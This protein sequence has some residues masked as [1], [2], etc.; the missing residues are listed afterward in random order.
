MATVRQR[1]LGRD[2]ARLRE[3][4]GLSQEQVAEQ[5]GW[6]R[7]KVGRIEAAST[8]PKI[9]DVEALLGLYGADSAEAAMLAK[10]AKDAQ[11]RGW[12]TAFN[13]VFTGSFVGLEDEACEIRT[14]ETQFVPGLLQ[15]EAYAR[16]V[17][18][19]VRPDSPESVHRRVQA[20]MAR[21]TLLG[22]DNAPELHAVIDESVLRRTIGGPEVMNA[23]FGRLAAMAKQPNITLQV[24][25]F[26]AGAHAGLEG[27]FVLLG[28]P[29]PADPDIPYIEGQGGDVYLEAADQVA[30]I[31]LVWDRVVA[32][33]GSPGDSLAMITELAEE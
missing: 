25:P 17:I 5:L 15:T 13:D 33:A 20:R 8:M 32:A 29:D 14:W 6:S 26:T 27:P 2:L 31:R 7:P 16:A 18:S 21:R 22:R 24:L 3:R 11:Q 1:R 30:R 19:A 9:A 23:Q 4:A 28:F 10:L 12:W